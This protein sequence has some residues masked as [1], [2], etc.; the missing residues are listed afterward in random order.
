[1][2]LRT[3]GL[4]LD[5]KRFDVKLREVVED[6]GPEKPR[7]PESAGSVGGGATEALAAPM[8]GTIV[9][10]LVAVGDEVEAGQSV[11]VLEAMKMENSILAAHAGKVE[12]LKV[13][14]GQS[15]ETGATIAIIR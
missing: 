8:Q 1:V 5:G 11:C 3:F 12:E 14:P 10:V 9:K 13:E 4:E 15:V 6:A 2:A 7:P